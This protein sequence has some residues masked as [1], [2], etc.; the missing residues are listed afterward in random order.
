[1]L[2]LD[3][4][5]LAARLPRI[6]LIEA[7][8]DAFREGC[9]AP[10]RLHYEIGR[11]GDGRSL[12]LMP[13]WRGDRSIGIKLVT[14]V[15]DNAARGLP[16]VHASYVL[17][18]AITGETRA[19]LNGT[20]LTLRRTAAA[21]GL[22]ARYLAS[23]SASRLLMVGAGQ[24]VPH[25]VLTHGLVRPIS[26]VQIWARRPERAEALAASLTRP[27]LDVRVCTNLE[28]GVRWAQIIS[29]ATLSREP[30]IEGQW[31]RPGQHLDLIGAFRPDMREV[32]AL[33]VQRA[34][35]YVD[36]RVGALAESGELIHAL[37]SGAIGPQHVRGELSELVRGSVDGRSATTDITLFKSVGCALEDLAAAEFALQAI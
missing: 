34:A 7:L 32:D 3:A 20:E 14:V 11:K 35:V 8:A 27:G 10:A 26:Q 5:E 21:S 12:L 23:P 15:P 18:D 2:N 17:F 6:G 30:L 16:A 4:I 22:A 36:T 9:V 1:L 19:I 24:L 31:L 29:T 28:A 33:A 37:A 13:A 25:V